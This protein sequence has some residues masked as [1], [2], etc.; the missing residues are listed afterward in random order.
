M[1]L[2]TL[3]LDSSHGAACI[4]GVLHLTD[5][6]GWGSSNREP[7]FTGDLIEKAQALHVSW[8]R[9]TTVA[10]PRELPGRSPQSMT[11]DSGDNHRAWKGDA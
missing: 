10:R 6:S 8:L 7:G 1:K 4:Q 2:R 3:L 5:R 9:A 11:G